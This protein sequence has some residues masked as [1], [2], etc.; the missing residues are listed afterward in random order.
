M[1]LKHILLASKRSPRPLLVTRK[2]VS[3]VEYSS[4]HVCLH[5]M[6]VV[7]EEKSIAGWGRKWKVLCS[8]HIHSKY[9]LFAHL[10]Q[11]EVTVHGKYE[12]KFLPYQICIA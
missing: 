10:F 3:H 12:H 4:C 11:F 6:N 2:N 8:H 5:A 9:S 7:A 1:E